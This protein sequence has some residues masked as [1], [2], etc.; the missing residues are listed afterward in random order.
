ML[1]DAS[2]ICSLYI[3]SDSSLNAQLPVIEFTSLLHTGVS[4]CVLCSAQSCVTKKKLPV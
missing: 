4:N 1:H 3:S 2:T